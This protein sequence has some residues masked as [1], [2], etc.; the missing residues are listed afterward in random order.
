M[1]I[2]NLIN[3]K[4]I[5]EHCRKIKHQFNT[6]ELAVLIYRNKKMDV[7]EKIAA[8]K[9]LIADYP[10]ME[11]IERIN[12][13]HYDSVKEMIKG[14]INRLEK[15]YKELI[16]DSENAIYSWVEF[17]KSTQRWSYSNLIEN[18]KKTYKEIQKNVSDYINEYDDTL[19]YRITKKYF[20]KKEKIIYAKYSVINKQ[21]KLINITGS[22]DEDNYLDINN[23]FLNIP[24]PF[25]KG[26]ILISNDNSMRNYGDYSKI[27]V[28]EYLCTWKEG[29]KEYLAEGN[30]DS[31]DMIAYAYYL[32]GE[33]STKFVLDVKWDYDSFE[34]YD[35]KLEGNNRILKDISSF[36]K[37]EIGLELFVHAYDAYKAENMRI[38]P[39][40]YT[41][42]GLKLAGFSDLDI[43]KENHEKEI[44]NIPTDKENEK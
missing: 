1:D 23:I 2:Y 9:E 26:D 42:E 3:S 44:Y 30:C 10:D 20:G 7:D 6:E 15:L 43:L 41:D 29:L 35:G 18:S 28:L 5:S 24:T 36:L 21:S 17:N 40:F 11:V 22:E 32:Y 13:K 37:G 38:L 19:S 8:Y 4:A 16:E 31:S 39:D 27:F 33:N 34:Y 12:C 14:E 25:K